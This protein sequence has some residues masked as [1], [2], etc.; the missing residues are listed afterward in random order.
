MT[1]NF[2]LC[3]NCFVSLGNDLNYINQYYKI[4]NEIKET[5]MH[6]II[7]GNKVT[8]LPPMSKVKIKNTLPTTLP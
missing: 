6:Q 5:E 7:D 3:N 2:E 4:I 8:F 1:K